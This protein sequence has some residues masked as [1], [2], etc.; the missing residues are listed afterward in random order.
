[1]D[2]IYEDC[3]CCSYTN[4]PMGKLGF[5]TWFRCRACGAEYSSDLDYIRENKPP[6]LDKWSDED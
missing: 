5:K 6:E 4:V 1:M 3:P 2:G